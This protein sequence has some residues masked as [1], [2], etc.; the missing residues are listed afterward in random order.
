MD[1]SR[2][3]LSYGPIPIAHIDTLKVLKTATHNPPQKVRQ[4]KGRKR[5]RRKRRKRRKRKK[6]RRR[7]KRRRKRRGEREQQI[8]QTHTHTTNKEISAVYRS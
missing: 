2:D 3:P 1:C 5:R 4:D 6:K 7:R 8:T